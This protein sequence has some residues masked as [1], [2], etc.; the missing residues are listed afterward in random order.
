[1]N[2][3]NLGTDSV[4]SGID[5]TSQWFLQT[6]ETQLRTGGVK[7]RGGGPHQSKTMMLADLTALVAANGERDPTD[8]VL[9]RNV[10]GKSSLRAREAA[11]YRLRQLYGLDDPAPICRALLALWARDPAGRP[12]LALLCALARDPSLRDGATA[13]LDAVPGT[14]V[15]W[16]AIAAAFESRNPGRLGAKMAKSLAQNAA[17]SWTQAGYLAGAVRKL[18]V[19]ANPTPTVAAYAAL[20]ASYCGFGGPALL[21]S[22][23]LDVVDRPAEDRLSLLRQAEG[24]GLVR[25]RTVGDVL[26]IEV[27]RPSAESLGIADLVRS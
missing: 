18:R 3:L 8:A 21:Q 4:L 2:G 11:L 24:L 23:W 19:R 10:L 25:V 5:Q 13:V 9:N 26:E 20:I 1:L 27:L 12:M 14:Q 22:R 7:L 15:R 6:D 16:P 17:S